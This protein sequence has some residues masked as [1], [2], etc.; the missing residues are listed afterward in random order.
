MRLASR[1]SPCSGGF[2]VLSFPFA[3]DP[4]PGDRVAGT[5][6]LKTWSISP[7]PLGGSSC[8]SAARAG[9]SPAEGAAVIATAG[10][11]SRA[12]RG[13]NPS[14]VR[15]R[16]SRPRRSPRPWAHNPVFS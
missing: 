10:A 13:V 7:S 12:S 3:V 6:P 8:G 5:R 9:S 15:V 16:P 14:S 2:F 1:P 4:C 11:P